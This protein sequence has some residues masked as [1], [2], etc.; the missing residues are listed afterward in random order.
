MHGN[1][2]KHI[3]FSW[4][5]LAL[6]SQLYFSDIV[7]FTTISARSTSLQVI[8]L[9]NNLYTEFDA[10]LDLH[11]VYKIETI[12][13]AYMVS[14]LRLLGRLGTTV[15]SHTQVV[16]GLP[17]RNGDKHALE[18]AS[19]SLNL[20]RIIDGIAIPHLEGEKLRI[21]IGLHSG[22]VKITL[23][24]SFKELTVIV[25]HHLSYSVRKN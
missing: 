25:S 8:A 1:D 12:G 11:D 9:L 2:A 5:T 21:R 18:I 19:M 10:E 20:L 3:S 24:T 14:K 16:S 7:G 17:L 6:T 15:R 4:S 22:E 23:I 13:D